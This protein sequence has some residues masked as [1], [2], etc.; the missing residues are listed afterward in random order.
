M[1]TAEQSEQRHQED[2]HRDWAI[3][4]RLMDKLAETE[5]E[6]GKLE[7]D[8]ARSVIVTSDA[9]GNARVRRQS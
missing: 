3:I 4:S 9:A 7:L 6:F 8:M 1:L 2:R 5:D